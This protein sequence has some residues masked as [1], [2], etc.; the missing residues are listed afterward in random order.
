MHLPTTTSPAANIPLQHLTHAP[1]WET[2]VSDHYPQN[3]PP[4]RHSP[5]IHADPADTQFTRDNDIVRWAVT[6]RPAQP[7]APGQSIVVVPTN[8]GDPITGTIQNPKKTTIRTREFWLETA[9]GRRGEHTITAPL[10]WC[11]APWWARAGRYLLRPFIHDDPTNET[12]PN[13]SHCPHLLHFYY[14]QSI[15]PTIKYT[16]FLLTD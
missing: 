10:K 16:S 7:L 9:P 13:G 6:C 1:S 14:E 5:P 15:N 3:T 2:F 12:P 11:D 4:P 8:T